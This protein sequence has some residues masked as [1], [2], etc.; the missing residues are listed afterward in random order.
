MYALTHLKILVINPLHK[1]NN[2]LM[3][4][5]FPNFKKCSVLHF[6]NSF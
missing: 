6:C 3:K 5:I 4:N 1:I 2:I